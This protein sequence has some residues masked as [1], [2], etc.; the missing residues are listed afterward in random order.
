MIFTI[1]QKEN[2]DIPLSFLNENNIYKICGIAIIV[3]VIMIPICDLLHL[4]PKS[5]LVLEALALT[6]FGTSW[7]VK[8]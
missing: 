1:G 5:T 2:N 6:S 3:F 7:L 8:G 4:F